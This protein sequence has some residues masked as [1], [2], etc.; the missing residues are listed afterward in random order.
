MRWGLTLVG[1]VAAILLLGTAVALH[2][3]TPPVF[4][5]RFRTALGT[6]RSMHQLAAEWSVETARVQADPSA[7][8]DD[9][10]GFVPRMQRLKDDLSESIANIPD[11]PG[12]LT[13]DVRAYLATMDALRERVERFKTA[14]AV[15]RNSERYFPLASADLVLRAEQAGNQQLAR[16]GADLAVEMDSYL[17]SPN[18]TTKELLRGRIQKVTEAGARETENVASSVENFTAH[19]NVLFDKRARSKELFEG[20]AASTLS[21]RTNPLTEVLE[22]VR[23]ERRRTKSLYQG[24]AVGCGAGALLM[25]IFVGFTKRSAAT[26][27]PA[28]RQVGRPEGYAANQ[29]IASSRE[30]I[31]VDSTITGAGRFVPSL[32]E[33]TEQMPVGGADAIGAVTHKDWTGTYTMEALLT[34]GALAGLM[35]QSMGAYTRRMKNDL[36]ALSGSATGGQDKLGAEETVQLWG[37]VRGDVGRLD[38]VAR[39]LL[40]LGR[41]LAPS[42]RVSI[43]V[44]QCLGEVLE[45]TEAGNFCVVERQFE[46]IPE[47]HGSKTEIRLIFTMC[48]DYILRGLRELGNSQAELVVRTKLGKESVI[49]A[50]IYDGDW[51]APEHQMGQF[52]PFYGSMNP[53]AGLALPA[54]RYLARRHGG[55]TVLDKFTDHRAVLSVQLPVDARKE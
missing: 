19:A 8:F 13:A 34:T 33:P 53:K 3:M 18:E 10:A 36:S 41:H 42:D 55:T 16:E 52:I 30:H 45:E 5:G 17:A 39:R 6:V 29:K 46:E 7:N 37:R 50:F 51:V 48:V 20:I 15:I 4:E 14:Y 49:I 22:S 43:D 21:E 23:N 44:N 28:P 32:G 27:H 31:V 38:F 2:F 12:R 47:V 40:M 9:L 1:T 35:G 54:A 26:Q 11:L 24:S 25:W